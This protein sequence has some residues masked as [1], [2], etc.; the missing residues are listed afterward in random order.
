MIKYKIGKGGTSILR[1]YDRETW[2]TCI[3]LCSTIRDYQQFVQDVAEQGVEIVEGPNVKHPSYSTLRS[4]AYP[5]AEEQ[6]DMR[7]WD[8]VNGTTV[9][10]DTIAA[11][12]EQYPKTIV[13][14]TTIGPVPDWVLELANTPLPAD[15]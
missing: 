13:A 6:N 2:T 10:Q 1:D 7:Y 9:W 15:D 14:E 3:P 8:A 4:K 5:S 11:I 12:K